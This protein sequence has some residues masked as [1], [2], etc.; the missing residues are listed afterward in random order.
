MIGLLCICC[1]AAPKTTRV[2]DSS[3]KH[4]LSIS[5]RGAI[6]NNR[7]ASLGRISK[8]GNIYNANGAKIGTIKGTS[9]PRDSVRGGKPNSHK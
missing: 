5:P 2:Y 9:H 6:T 4:V 7:G 1:G 3:G 8:S